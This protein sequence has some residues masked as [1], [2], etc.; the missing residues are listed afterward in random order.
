MNGTF[1]FLHGTGQ[2]KYEENET[3]I[4]GMLERNTRLAGFELVCVEWGRLNPDIKDLS[5]VLPKPSVNVDPDAPVSAELAL[6]AFASDF[7]AEAVADAASPGQPDSLTPMGILT[8]VIA[9]NRYGLT[10]AAAAFLQSIVRYFRDGKGVRELVGRQIAA[11]NQSERVVVAGHSLGGVIALDVLSDPSFDGRV[12]LLVTA[13]SQAP[14]LVQLGAWP[15]VPPGKDAPPAKPF[16]PWF[17]VYNA[18]DPLA[19]LAADVFASNATP[20]SD[21]AIRKPKDLVGTHSD[22]FTSAALYEWIADRL[23]PAT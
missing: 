9:D 3:R 18:R 2:Q 20:P 17:N 11:A 14:L 15:T 8:S 19:F 1:I 13:G 4:R 7:Y 12:D 21:M 22:Y 6:T 16:S 10:S 5:E 23:A